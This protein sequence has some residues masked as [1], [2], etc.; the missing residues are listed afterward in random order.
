[1]GVNPTYKM[2]EL[3]KTERRQACIQG[4]RTVLEKQDNSEILKKRRRFAEIFVSCQD[5]ELAALLSGISTASTA[6]EESVKLLCGK[7]L[8]RRV[9]RLLQSRRKLL[10][11]VRTGLERIAFNRCNDA[12]ALAFADQSSLTRNAIRQMDLSCVSAIKRDK[13]GGVDIKL[14]DRQSALEA[15]MRLDELESSCGSAEEFLN[16]LNGEADGHLENSD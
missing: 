8:Q 2:S 1:M 3:C 13:D 5:A 11:N 12:V 10:A 14:L 6:A 7:R 4:K 16:A 9:E 15:L